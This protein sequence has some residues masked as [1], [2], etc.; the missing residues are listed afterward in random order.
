M[1]TLHD[2][3]TAMAPN[4]AA[5]H[6]LAQQADSLLLDIQNQRGHNGRDGSWRIT[7][8]PRPTGGNS[9]ILMLYIAIHN[10]SDQTIDTLARRLPR[11]DQQRS[12]PDELLYFECRNGNDGLAIWINLVDD[13]D[14][15]ETAA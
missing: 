9:M 2:I 12:K 1:T 5:I 6:E 14:T 10:I 8:E 3:A 4:N 15:G 11:Y 7:A 13:T